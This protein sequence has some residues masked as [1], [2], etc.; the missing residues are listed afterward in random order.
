VLGDVNLIFGAAEKKRACPL[1]NESAAN[2]TLLKKYQHMIVWGD[3]LG[4]SSNG[5]RFPPN[6]P[7][8]RNCRRLRNGSASFGFFGSASVC[9]SGFFVL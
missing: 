5:H 1:S 7:G 8:D 4:N 9:S 2:N 6:L 3:G